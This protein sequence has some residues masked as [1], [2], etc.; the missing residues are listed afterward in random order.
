MMNMTPVI[1]SLEQALQAEEYQEKKCVEMSFEFIEMLIALLKVQ[2]N[3]IKIMSLALDI[4]KGNGI[5][6]RTE[7][8]D[9]KGTD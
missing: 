7:P 3:Q 6:V 8:D 4:L 1:D 2:D 5:E 9:N